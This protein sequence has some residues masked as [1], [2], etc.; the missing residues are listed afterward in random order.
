MWHRK[1]REKR[2]DRETQLPLTRPALAIV[3]TQPLACFPGCYSLGEFS[4]TKPTTLMIQLLLQND[5]C[6]AWPAD[7]KLQLCAGP[8][9]GLS[10]RCCVTGVSEAVRESR[11]R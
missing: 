1:K 10:M 4:C 8:A 5:G 3:C 7:T 9:L 11:Y 6:E 2:E